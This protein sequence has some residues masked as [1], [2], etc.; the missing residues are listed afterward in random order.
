MDKLHLK[1]ADLIEKSTGL[2]FNV[3]NLGSHAT[4]FVIRFNGQPY[5]Y[6]NQCAHVPIELDWQQGDFFNHTQDFLICATHGAQ[7]EPSTGR[8]V[9][10]PCKGK[11]LKPIKVIEQGN[12][13]II[14]L[15]S[16]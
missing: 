11:G 2:R 15:E 16:I 12:T 9:L 8:C 3:P 6:L 1:S 13:I 4:G 10:G 5:A 7:Y 14:D